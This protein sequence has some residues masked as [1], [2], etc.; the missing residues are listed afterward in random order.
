M[1]SKRKV[2]KHFELSIVT[3]DDLHGW[4]RSYTGLNVPRQSICPHHDPPFEYLIRSFF[5]P[6]KDLIVW[7]PRG[8]GK[9]RLA[10][11]ATL[12]DLHFKPGV[13]VRILGGSLEQSLRMWEHLLPD[14]EYNAR[15]LV[16]KMRPASRRLKWVN[17]SSAAV[18][19]QSQ[20]AVRGLR[21]QKLRCDEVEL[22]DPKIWEAAQLVTKSR[23]SGEGF[24]I[25]GAIDA[26]STVHRPYGLM[27]K[28]V[29]QAQAAG[30]PRI[31]RWCLLEVL[32]RC[33]PSRE[34]KTCP[35]WDEC[36]GVAKE[37][38]DGFFRIDDA[39]E[40][41][42]R[43][44]LE[45]WNNEMLCRKPS[46]HGCVFPSFDEQQHVREEMSVVS[47]PLS[48]GAG[49]STDN[50]QL[51]TDRSLFLAMDFG[52][53][54][55]FVCLWVERRGDG[56]TYVFDEYVQSMRT[57]DDHLKQIEARRWPKVR[58]VCCD[59]AG[60]GRNDQTAA[61]NIRVLRANGYVVRSRKS[62]IVEGLEMIRAALRP[63]SGSARL[64]IH[65]RCAKLIKAMRSYHYPPAGGELPAKDGEFDHPIDALRYYFVNTQASAVAEARTY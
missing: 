1:P 64:F 56:G 40:M 3:P 10:A 14:I 16:E 46:Q 47:G 22:F 13:A 48:V 8:G 45:T 57:T 51:T 42:R 15:H 5:E 62:S 44:S 33:P 29:E 49:P 58:H 53:A 25:S 41:K 61:S 35:L 4:V 23:A 9:T 43:V 20:R 12:L 6:A 52:F 34:C 32:E 59:P 19:T 37:K 30:S 65:P 55:P 27:N 7:A 28:V 2:E 54:N 18:L 17:G 38:C 26:L 50:G 39:I 36:R 31:V 11:V 21:V 63:A 24:G 60:A